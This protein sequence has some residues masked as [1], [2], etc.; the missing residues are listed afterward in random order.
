MLIFHTGKKNEKYVIWQG[1]FYRLLNVGST[2]LMKMEFREGDTDS[3][4]GSAYTP[5]YNPH[6]LS[7]TLISS[8]EIFNLS[9]F[10]SIFPFSLFLPCPL[11]KG[12]LLVSLWSL[13]GCSSLFVYLDATLSFFSFY[14]SPSSSHFIFLPSLSFFSWCSSIQGVF[15]RAENTK[16]F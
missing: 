15:M 13:P 11:W 12:F 14:S 16:G 8:H 1:L 2:E 5:M 4:E 6:M 10:F 3:L 7:L 9:L